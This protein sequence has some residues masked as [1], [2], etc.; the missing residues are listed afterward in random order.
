MEPPV[1]IN[2]TL[3]HTISWEHIR[4]LAFLLTETRVFSLQCAI[5]D[6]LKQQ[7]RS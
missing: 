6:L 2:P 5:A 1:A 7:R 3:F 4:V